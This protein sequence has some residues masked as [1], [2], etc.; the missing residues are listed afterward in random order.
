MMPR[1]S[2]RTTCASLIEFI[3]VI[4]VKQTSYKFFLTSFSEQVLH[5]IKQ[6]STVKFKESDLFKVYQS[7]DFS[8][9]THDSDLA[10]KMPTLMQLKDTLYSPDYRAFMEKITNL[11]PGTLTDEVRT[12]N[13]LEFGSRFY[14][15][16]LIEVHLLATGRQIALQ[17]ATQRAVIFYATMMSLETVKYLTL[18]T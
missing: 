15:S 18:Y 2:E 6:N 8:N 7:I 9:L 16:P 4:T 13:H 10:R 17:I 5:E 14:L 3:R 11:E 1:A 12:I